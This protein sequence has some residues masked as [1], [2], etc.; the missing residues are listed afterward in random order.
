M[1]FQSLNE[2]KPTKYINNWIHLFIILYP[3]LH[4]SAPVLR[5]HQGA[6]CFWLKQLTSVMEL[7]RSGYNIINKYIQALMHLVGFN[8]F[9]LTFGILIFWRTRRHKSIYNLKIDTIKMLIYHSKNAF[10]FSFKTIYDM[11]CHLLTQS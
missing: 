3:L 11:S 2:L 10:F 8:L 9:K 1:H 6:H 7:C 5:H 4:V